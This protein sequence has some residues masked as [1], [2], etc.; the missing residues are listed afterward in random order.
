M[1]FRVGRVDEQ[2]RVEIRFNQPMRNRTRIER[3]GSSELEVLIKKRDTQQEVRV[4][5][6]ATEYA[7]ETSTLSIQ[8]LVEDPKSISRGQE[9]D[10]LKLQF[11]RSRFFYS[12]SEDRYPDSAK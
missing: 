2:G 11:M 4:N 8:L 3:L 7:K 1:G 6:N 5:W 9:K 12:E 10:L